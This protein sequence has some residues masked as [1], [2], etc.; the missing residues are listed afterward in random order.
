[1][2]NVSGQVQLEVEGCELATTSEGKGDGV[3]ATPSFGCGEMAVAGVVLQ[4][5]AENYSHAS[6]IGAF[7]YVQL[8]GLAPMVN[9]SCDP[10]CGVH[11]NQSGGYDLIVRRTIAPG[12]EITFDYAMRNYSVAHFPGSCQCGTSLCRGA[13]TGWKDLTAERKAA[14]SGMV[15]PYLLAMDEANKPA[16]P[17]S[18]DSSVGSRPRS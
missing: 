6:Q 10:N 11:V 4:R 15:A 16:V 2:T 7:E 8:G 5:L 18:S 17:L 14:Y 1:M 12:E 3:F 13:V 9:H